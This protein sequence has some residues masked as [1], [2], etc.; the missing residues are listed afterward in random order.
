MELK[1]GENIK[2]LRKNKSMTQEQ[3]SE[4]LNISCA[5]VSKWESAD[6]YPDITMI[7]PLARVFDVGIDEL[8]GYNDA[9]V[10]AEIKNLLAEYLEL[11]ARG[12]YKEATELIMQARKTYPNDYGIMLRYMW[13]LAGGSADNR[14]ETLNL[15][16]DEFMRICD[17]ILG[18]C[19]D[20]SLRLEA[21]TMKAKLL[22]A[23]G[24]TQAALAILADFPSW[25][26]S[27]EQRTELLFAKDTDDFRYY[28]KRNLYELADFAADK[29][30]KVIFFDS[31]LAMDEKVVKVETL[32]DMLSALY[33]KSSETIFAVIL[34]S[35]WGRLAND[36]TFRG[37][38]TADI[39]R[40]RKKQLNAVKS[41]TQ[42]SMKDTA[43]FDSFC[44]PKGTDNLLKWTL[45]YLSTCENS[46]LA[47]LRENKEYMEM[48]E[49]Y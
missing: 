34:K 43:L 40:I 15:Y 5:A 4:L 1:I 17:C 19:T 13:D 42:A 35:L 23:A 7:M 11:Q 6:T 29:A 36:L 3:L 24:D 10:E 33:D 45:N 21:M 8:M 14:P 25:Y 32:G 16:H 20:E 30:V 31:T 27:S 2:R 44:M 46:I 28:V 37:G 49:K 48:F 18:G 41:V 38:K 9:K 26:Q 12:K 39:I 22:H 47:K